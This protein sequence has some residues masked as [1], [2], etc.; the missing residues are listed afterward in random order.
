MF[1]SAHSVD[2]CGNNGNEMKDFGGGFFSPKLFMYLSVFTLCMWL[3]R[4]VSFLAVV[5]RSACSVCHVPKLARSLTQLPPG[6][7]R[8]MEHHSI[9]GVG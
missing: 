9:H 2:G 7:W 6:M 1:H 5:E 4:D 8:Q 3:L